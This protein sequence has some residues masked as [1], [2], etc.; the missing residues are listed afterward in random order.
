MHASAG[1]ATGHHAASSPTAPDDDDDDVDAETAVLRKGLEATRADVRQML[2]TLDDER[3]HGEQVQRHHA[4]QVA[5]L[6]RQLAQLRDALQRS[7]TYATELRAQLAS[8]QTR[9]EGLRRRAEA[10]THE[11]DTLRARAEHG[12]TVTQALADAERQAAASGERHTALQSQVEALTPYVYELAG[13]LEQRRQRQDELVRELA[14]VRALRARD[15]AEAEAMRSRCEVAERT[16]TALQRDVDAQ[17]VLLEEEQRAHG[18]A[19]GVLEEKYSL[20]KR[21]VGAM[22]RRR[23]DEQCRNGGG[24]EGGGRGGRSVDGSEG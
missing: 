14:R 1:A 20:L 3:Q 19:R 18:E 4:E 13:E 5:E 12:A 17:R 6:S 8:A 11:A 24:G 2:L 15:Q 21:M 9:T 23:L 16:V 7:E 22:R 10:A